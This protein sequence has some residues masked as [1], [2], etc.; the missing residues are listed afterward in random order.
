[1]PK[2]VKRVMVAV[3]LA[4]L[5][6]LAGRVVEW[7]WDYYFKPFSLEVDAYYRAKSGQKDIARGAKIDLGVPAVEGQTTDDRGKAYWHDLE[8]H[9]TK[10][11]SIRVD[12]PGYHLV[13]GPDV[14][15]RRRCIA[16]QQGWPAPRGLDLWPTSKA[17]ARQSI[18]QPPK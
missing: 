13:R 17:R 7:G 15:L 2:T 16:S 3:L 11:T 12:F 1:M 18:Y 9:P 10:K 4:A 5:G 6:A 14:A 8:P